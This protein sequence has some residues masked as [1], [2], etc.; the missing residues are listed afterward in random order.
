MVA[1]LA[2]SSIVAVVLLLLDLGL[3]LPHTTRGWLRYLPLLLAALPLLAAFRRFI[4]GP[5]DGRVALLVEERFPELAGLLS[6]ALEPLSGDGEVTRAF[7]RRA[8]ARLGALDLSGVA[9]WRLRQLATMLGTGLLALAPILAIYPGG[10]SGIWQRWVH[11]AE[12]PAEGAMSVAG[13]ERGGVH[14]ALYEDISAADT[15]EGGFGVVR[16]LVDPPSYSGLGSREWKGDGPLAALP[17]SRIEVRGEVPGGVDSV[18]VEVIGGGRLPVRWGASADRA[19]IGGSAAPRTWNAV[20]TLAP[21]ERGLKVEGLA[22]EGVVGRRVLPLTTLMDEPPFVEL[23]TPESDMVVATARGEIVVRARARDDYG[24]GEFEL[25]WIRS[26]GSGESFSFEE[27]RWRWGRVVPAESSVRGEYRLDL[28]EAGLEPGDVVHLRA[29][30]RDRNTVTGPGEGVSRTRVIRV[31]REEEM[32]EATTL[33]GFPI[34]AEREPIL[35]QRM[36]IL[37]T[38]RLLAASPSLVRDSLLAA[39]VE[40]AEEQARLRRQVGDQALAPTTGAADSHDDGGDHDHDADPVLAVN[41][42]LL[43]AYNL[44]WSAEGELR[45]A[46]LAASLPFQ[47]AALRI[48]QEMRQAERVFVRGRVR[49]AP[50]DLAEARGT[51]EIDEAAPAARSAVSALPTADSRAA[52]IELLIAGLA[53]GAF[54]E[55]GLELAAFAARLLADQAVDPAV[56]G[57]I[58]E[59]AEAAGRGRPEEALR[60]AREARARLAPSGGAVGAT[61]VP[62][63]VDQRSA[64]YLR[65]LAGRSAGGSVAGA[66]GRDG[67]GGGRRDEARSEMGGGARAETRAG[68]RSETRSGA[69]GAPSAVAPAA[70]F[71]FA[72]LQYESGDWDSAPLVPANLI[73][74]MAQYTEIPVA[75]EGVVVDLAGAEIFRYPILYLTG[76]LPVRFNDAESRNLAA[77]VERGG[78]VFIDDHNHDVDGA[79]HRTVTAELARIFGM[80]AL[81]PLPN[82]HEL[83]RSFFVFEDGPPTTSHE[84]NGWGDGLIHEE[85]FAIERDGRI[86]VL[87]SNKDY[88]SEWNYHAVNKR[89]LAVDN[90]RFGVNLIIYGLTR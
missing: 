3:A 24:V 62:G 70:P 69:G 61:W 20:W 53:A 44:M 74:A 7:L 45:V 58:A 89:F 88:S 13:A 14:G 67:A 73:H 34:E 47:Y 5:D 39:A 59:A 15:Q 30:A 87:Y 27:G 19:G 66:G 50:I 9:P 16:V 75:P 68:T 83:Y 81:R 4:P 60:L 43:E 56:G 41:R 8:D 17:G 12:W 48:L 65:A 85:L 46:E 86:G 76:H 6:T 54:G 21:G 32:A 72:T 18:A 64:A 35:S 37:L 33:V 42:S 79:F 77:Y 36:V 51:G 11:L 22:A 57:L 40:I 2:A 10:V 52:E 26:R 82:D 23:E 38:E 25:A 29:V 55:A 1:A 90:T 80:D 31:A 78:L 84:L 49:V 63:A 28:A 71:V